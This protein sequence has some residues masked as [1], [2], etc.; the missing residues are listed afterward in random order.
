[1]LEN[2][3]R[4]LISAMTALFTAVASISAAEPVLVADINI[5]GG[6]VLHPTVYD[7]QLAFA[8]NGGEEGEELWI[9]DGT[10]SGTRLLVDVVP[11]GASSAPA[12]L[13]AVGADFYFTADHPRQGRQLW[14]YSASTGQA[15]MVKVIN[16]NGSANP[17]TLVP[18]QGGLFFFADDGSHGQE[19]WFTD[20]SSAGTHLIRDIRAGSAG[21]SSGL[22]TGTTAILGPHIYFL[23]DDGSTGK[24][25]WRSDGTASGTTLHVDLVSGS[26]DAFIYPGF[27]ATSSHLF[28]AA[29]LNG[30]A[31]LVATDGDTTGPLGTIQASQLTVLADTLYF[32]GNDG[33]R[34][35]ELWT[36][37][38]EGI[39]IVQNLVPDSDGENSYGIGI[40][41]LARVGDRLLFSADSPDHLYDR[42]LW[43]SD[44]TVAGTDFMADIWT[45][46]RGTPSAPH[47]FVPFD[48][49]RFAFVASEGASFD[50]RR[51]Y[52]GQRDGSAVQRLGS[53]HPADEGVT[54]AKLFGTGN[55]AVFAIV[56]Y[57]ETENEL[58]ASTGGAPVRLL[59]AMHGAS[60]S[61]PDKITAFNGEVYFTATATT[62]GAGNDNLYRASVGAGASLVRDTNPGDGLFGESRD[63]FL[64]G[65]PYAGRL[66]F[67]GSD[68]DDP[69]KDGHG[70]ELW[71]TDG[72]TAGTEMVVELATGASGSRLAGSGPHMF[73]VLG[74]SMLFTAGIDGDHLDK[75]LFIAR[76]GGDTIELLKEINPGGGTKGKSLP[77]EMLVVGDTAYFTAIDGSH[78]RE[79]W[80]TNGTTSGTELV[81]DIHPSG[82]SMPW[83]PSGRPGVDF[84]TSMVAI[85]GDIF[86]PADDGSGFDLWTSNGTAAGTSKL[87]DLDDVSNLVVIG[88]DIVFVATDAS[89]GEEIWIS[90]VT[91]S[92]RRLTDIAS[93]SDGANPQYLTAFGDQVIFSADDGSTGRELYLLNAVSEEL[94]MLDIDAGSAEGQP[95]GFVPVNGVVCFV[96]G[97]EDHGRELWQT[98]GTLAGTYLVK[99]LNL[100][101]LDSDIGFRG[102]KSVVGDTLYFSAVTPAFGKELW[103]YTPD[104]GPQPQRSITID[105]Q[106]RPVDYGV[107]IDSG[108]LRDLPTTFDLLRFE[109]NHRLYFGKNALQPLGSDG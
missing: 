64:H 9:S 57:S 66:F 5:E 18:W 3:M 76:D 105:L 109:G 32:M 75:E 28:F 11:G 2:A 53:M 19:P 107:G 34:N 89:H 88:D 14:M 21:S 81:K 103:A 67:M 96:A 70:T 52:L 40:G 56:R 13:V 91:G 93:G 36:S 44:G 87:V 30:A 31:R 26:D 73:T 90:D 108:S 98:D 50:G 8:Y 83:D 7:G 42:E 95:A 45:G 62:S 43:I 74:D 41:D 4:R 51:L 48:A 35:R 68:G 15:R 54:T 92:A 46:G 58:W 27:A 102:P 49:D 60:S 86:F 25:L 85:D 59:S 71:V 16:E 79:L 78:G 10:S 77:R 12:D 1:M 84:G 61:D 33:P 72:T 106:P 24:E 100:G 99:D 17:H 55:G 29:N 6:G 23:A 69:K 47:N 65:T 97:D 101:H 22:P 94:L 38:G 20:G 80:K 104:R 82:S 63:L 37:D 39:S